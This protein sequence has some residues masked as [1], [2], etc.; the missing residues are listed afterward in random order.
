MFIDAEADNCRVAPAWPRPDP[1]ILAAFHGF[2]TASI[3][4]SQDR[5]G[6][7]HSAIRA[8]WRGARC[9][10]AALPVLTREGDN[11]AIHRALDEAH[12]GDVLVVNGFGETSRAVFGDLL[13]E[14]CLARGVRGVVLDGA[15]R[16][17]EAIAELGLPVWARAGTPAGPTKTGPGVIGETVAIG[18]A[19]VDPGDIVVA[20]GDGVA[21]IANDNAASVLDRLSAIERFEDSLRQQIREGVR[22]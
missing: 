13:A 9:V 5:L 4:D 21:V 15:T 17:L 2:P 16:D 6:L 7:V 1:E 14:I 3:G 18:G 22:A 12:P 11:L 8:Q 19:V 10:G 20:D